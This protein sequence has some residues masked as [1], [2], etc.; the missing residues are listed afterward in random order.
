MIASSA[1]MSMT[2]AFQVHDIQQTIAA[3]RFKGHRGRIAQ[4]V[5]RRVA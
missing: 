3:C 4:A 5:F 2:G 1:A